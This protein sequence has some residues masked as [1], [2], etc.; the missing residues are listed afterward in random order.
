M[1]AHCAENG[2]RSATAVLGTS[3]RSHGDEEHGRDSGGPAPRRQLESRGSSGA[4]CGDKR[5]QV[6]IATVRAQNAGKPQIQVIPLT[7]SVGSASR[8]ERSSASTMTTT[9]DFYLASGLSLRLI[10]LDLQG[11]E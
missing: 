11:L 3:R 10:P 9:N 1:Q 8:E 7:S 4:Q 6:D 2:S 5:R